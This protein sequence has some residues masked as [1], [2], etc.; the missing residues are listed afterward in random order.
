MCQRLRKIHHKKSFNIIV[1]R[2]RTPRW[3][4]YAPV[5]DMSLCT[6]GCTASAT[7]PQGLRIAEGSLLAQRQ[8]SGFRAGKRGREIKRAAESG[9]PL[10]LLPKLHQRQTEVVLRLG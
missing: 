7:D 4:M 3:G 2:E 10:A 9:T 1:Y 6:T 5:Y 8:P